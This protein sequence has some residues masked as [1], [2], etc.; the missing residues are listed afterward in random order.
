MRDIN[1]QEDGMLGGRL[2]DF[3]RDAD[4]LKGDTRLECVLDF[5]LTAYY[6]S[7]HDFLTFL[8]CQ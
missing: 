6:T 5:T 8:R 2:K 3:E 1:A 7:H 4:K